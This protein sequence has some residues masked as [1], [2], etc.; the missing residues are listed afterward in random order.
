MI[1]IEHQWVKTYS[2]SST[3]LVVKVT[4]TYIPNISIAWPYINISV[5]SSPPAFNTHSWTSS[6]LW[7]SSFP[8]IYI[9]TTY[10]SQIVVNGSVRGVPIWVDE[11]QF[12]CFLGVFGDAVYFQWVC[13]WNKNPHSVWEEHWITSNLFPPPVYSTLLH[14]NVQ[15][16]SYAGFN[17]A[18]TLAPSK[19]EVQHSSDF[20][21]KPFHGL[22][23][24][25][26][27]MD[28][29][30]TIKFLNAIVCIDF[31]ITS[32]FLLTPKVFSQAL[33]KFLILNQ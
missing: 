18:N 17:F 32:N 1:L 33:Q 9:H 6:S 27:C 3:H 24:I 19:Q 26:H 13:G 28:T 15:G 30:S 14:S 7:H 11:K 5:Y 23:Y 31:M 2:K 22:S 29:Y 10:I 20:F 8:P 21:W 12:G 25:L 4:S 16:Y